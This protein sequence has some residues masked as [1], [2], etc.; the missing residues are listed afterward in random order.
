MISART[1]S[2]G[3]PSHERCH[4]I[5]RAHGS[6]TPAAK[7]RQQDTSLSSAVA[8]NP[9]TRARGRIARRVLSENQSDGHTHHTESSRGQSPRLP[10]S[11]PGQTG[12]LTKALKPT[13]APGKATRRHGSKHSHPRQHRNTRI[14]SSLLR[15]PAQHRRHRRRIIRRK[16]SRRHLAAHHEKNARAAIPPATNTIVP[17][18]RPSGTS[19]RNWEPAGDTPQIAIRTSAHPNLPIPLGQSRQMDGKPREVVAQPTRTAGS[20][21]C[22]SRF[23]T[24]AATGKTGGWRFCIVACK[25]LQISPA[26]GLPALTAVRFV[27]SPVQS[28]V[29]SRFSPAVGTADTSNADSATPR[30]ARR[31]LL[32]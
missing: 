25:V 22:V 20:I 30:K 26:R 15:D 2:Q 5:R 12:A 14:A 11:L 4:R 3:Y 19:P 6:H 24:T 10:R 27:G 9:T 31:R 32:A 28:P 16:Q 18:R 17:Q 1:T 7:G 23:S 13:A 21:P 8:M 29:N